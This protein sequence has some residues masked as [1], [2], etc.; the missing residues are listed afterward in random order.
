A[1]TGYRGSPRGRGQSA[2]GC[3]APAGGG[4]PPTRESLPAQPR[5]NRHCLGCPTG[6][7]VK[8]DVQQA[9]CAARC[10]IDK[11][12]IIIYP[13]CKLAALRPPR[14]KALQEQDDDLRP[15]HPRFP[16]EG[17]SGRYVNQLSNHPC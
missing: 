9:A 12:K 8:R 16:A 11:T 3:P 1:S 10:D 14:A 15:F 7:L 6:C 5:R 4:S 17:L 2:P 13:A